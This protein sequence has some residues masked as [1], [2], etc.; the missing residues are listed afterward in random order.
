MFVWSQTNWQGQ[1]VIAHLTVQVEGVP[2]FG[3]LV[4]LQTITLPMN[5][6]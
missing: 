1:L 5:A 2:L 4:Q 3:Q 6:V